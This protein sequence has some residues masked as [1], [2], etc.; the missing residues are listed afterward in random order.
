VVILAGTER[1]GKAPKI[2]SDLL[3]D[4][5]RNKVQCSTPVKLLSFSSF[6]LLFFLFV[7]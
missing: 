7:L 6:F 5:R 1:D 3:A 2:V 4:L